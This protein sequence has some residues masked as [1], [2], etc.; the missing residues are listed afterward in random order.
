MRRDDSIYVTQYNDSDNLDTLCLNIVQQI[1][2]HKDKKGIVIV[3]IGT[4]RSTGDSL[5]PLVGSR[6]KPL[7]KKYPFVKVIGTMDTPAH[8]QRLPDIM[9]ELKE[10]YADYLVIAIDAA[11]GK[12]ESIGKLELKNSPICPGSGVGKDIA[13]IG[14]I[15]ITGVVNVCGFMD[16]A[17]L[18]STRLCFI[19]QMSEA[20]SKV[21]K[22]SIIRVGRSKQFKN[23]AEA[24]VT[25]EEY[26]Y[27]E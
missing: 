9:V 21:A 19:M 27:A 20:L 7:E 14:D 11:L 16:F 15:S 23:I 25:K 2:T 5:G 13:P 8:A 4:D 6:L 17:V 3:C 12:S 24:A 26:S 18:Q 1:R 10:K 22:Q